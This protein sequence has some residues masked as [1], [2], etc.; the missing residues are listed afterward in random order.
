[1]GI[2]RNQEVAGSILRSVEIDH[3]IYSTVILSLSLIQEG[4]LPVICERMY[5]E[6]WLAA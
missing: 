3:G 6:Y 4:K 5:T 2:R 1:M